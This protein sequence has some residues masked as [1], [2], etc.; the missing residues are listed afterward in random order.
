MGGWD[1]SAEWPWLETYPWLPMA[2]EQTHILNHGLPSPAGSDIHLPLQPHL[3][4]SSL[5]P[6]FLFPA[7]WSLSWSFLLL[8]ALFPWCLMGPVPAHSS[9]LSFHVCFLRAAFSGQVT[10]SSLGPLTYTLSQPSSLSFMASKW[11]SYFTLLLI[12]SL[13]VWLHHLTVS[14]MRVGAMSLFT[15]YSFPVS[16]GGPDTIF[17]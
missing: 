4:P 13:S 8:G 11:L 12:D 16:D 17:P 14:S 3:E 9:R 1:G 15:H 6:T 5:L 2:L 7:P 10:P